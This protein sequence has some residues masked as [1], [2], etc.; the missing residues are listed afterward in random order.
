[1][2]IKIL[3]DSIAKDASYCV[4][5]G[6]SC[7]IND[8]LL[9][10]T[11]AK[12]SYLL[13]NLHCMGIEVAQINAIVISHEHW[14]HIDGLWRILGKKT[15]MPV[16]GCPRFSETVKNKIKSLNGI[17]IESES[18]IEISHNIFTTGELAGTYKDA[19]MPEQSVVVKTEKG[20]S[21]ITGCSHPGIITIVEKVKQQFPEENIYAVIG[22]FHLKDE[23]PEKIDSIIKQLSILGVQKVGPAHCC[24]EQ[25]VKSF[26]AAYNDQ[27][28]SVN[29]G[30]ILLV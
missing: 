14:D 22:G 20:M 25:A 8:H 30:D 3:F 5:W 28:F 11:G 26:H 12:G 24:G 18:F 9:F 21:I 1:M 19:Y 29:V 27:F 13:N 7:L 17:I 10:D 23:S 15:N 16:Y 2:E 6:F 4:G